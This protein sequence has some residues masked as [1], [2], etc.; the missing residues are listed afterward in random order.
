MVKTVLGVMCA[1]SLLGLAVF[2]AY[3]WTPSAPAPDENQIRATAEQYDVRIIR[4]KWGVPHIYGARDPDAAFGL[5]YA[6]AEDDWATLQ[7]TLLFVR[8]QLAQH[9][10]SDG[11][12][13]DYLVQLLKADELIEARY[14]S[15]L[16]PATRAL[17]E[18]YADG[19]NLWATENSGKITRG[20]LPI[21]GKDIVAGFV[22]RTPFFFGL[23]DDLQE[24]FA[25]TRQ[26]G[27]SEKSL[28]AFLADGT[29]APL[30]GSNAFAVAPSR[31][32]DGHTRLMVNSHQPFTGPVA[33]YEA[34]IK[35]ETGWD[36]IG[37]LFP[38]TPLVSVG[39][40]P[41]LGWAHT[42]NKPDL[43]DIYVLETDDPAK[44]TRYKFD[45]AWREFE[46]SKATLRVKLFGNF[47]WPVSRDV[48]WSTHGPVIVAK[49]GVYAF[50]YAGMDNIRTVEQW[51][52]MGR[53][54]NFDEWRA[55]METLAVPSFNTVYADREGNIG[56]FYNANMP[57]R[58]KGW[59]WRAYLPGDTSD[60]LWQSYHSFADL[61]QLVNPGSGWVFSANNTPFKATD[62]AFNADPDGFPT[63]FGLEM[64]LTNRAMRALAQYE[65]DPVISE[66]DFLTYRADTN[67]APGSSARELVDDLVARDFGAD[68]DLTAAQALLATWTGSTAKTD[69]AAA[70]AVITAV[71]ARGYLLNDR[72]MDPV[73]ALRSTLADLKTVF[74]RLDP[75][76]GEVN[77]LDRGSTN[78]P[79]A[80]GPDILRAIYFEDT[81][82]E[83]GFV[84]A[85]GGDT[86]ILYADWSPEGDLEVQT[87]HQFG[88]ATLDTT[89]PHYDDQAR[90]FAAGEYKAMPMTLEGVL[91]EAT[92][93][94]RPGK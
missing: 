21:T 33:W 27:V 91:A 56:F 46:R 59:D 83:K 69:R 72:V 82:V 44:P 10:G 28:T 3:T 12:L 58:E 71:R 40:N 89:S 81:L 50:R 17:V 24:L 54:Q 34:R 78:L 79:L 73:E 61:P 45:G 47:S 1:V 75:A 32:D 5:A 36:V 63:S 16:K 9:K 64:H 7:E 6:H 4:D 67:Y 8:G 51:Y 52:E 80:G 25:E 18:A 84:T 39:T 48:L 13:T 11:V 93:D 60:T 20:L 88:S 42:V 29:P 14:D 22:T 37:G 57:R 2:A 19:L 65:A 87:I 38:G 26:R 86:Y 43:L 77:R 30:I 66:A 55:A 68:E 62:D 41:N 49:H 85:A 92:R 90:L 31:S 70:L 23:D 94:Y 35:S 74:G 76:W 53:A 15:D